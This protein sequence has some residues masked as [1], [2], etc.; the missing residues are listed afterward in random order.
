MN[1][2]FRMEKLVVIAAHPEG[3][4]VC[5]RC[6][7]Y[8]LEVNP[9]CHKCA[10]SDADLFEFRIPEIS[11]LIRTE[12]KYRRFEEKITERQLEAITVPVGLIGIKVEHEKEEDR[13]EKKDFFP[14]SL[15]AGNF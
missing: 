3:Y 6:G 1:N 4:K 5:M 9:K 11:R 7:A 15:Q 8:N 13:E 10:N 2:K 12:L 14:R